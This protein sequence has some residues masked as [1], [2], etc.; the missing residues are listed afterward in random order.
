VGRIL[1]QSLDSF[2]RGMPERMKLGVWSVEGLRRGMHPNLRTAE[3]NKMTLGVEFNI[4]RVY[5]MLAKMPITPDEKD[6]FLGPMEENLFRLPN[7]PI[8]AIVVDR[9]NRNQN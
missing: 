3:I 5:K 8:N 4:A 9:A 7:I 1:N 2:V 6:W